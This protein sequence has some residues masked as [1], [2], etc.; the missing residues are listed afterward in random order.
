MGG[1]SKSF[2][3][4]MGSLGSVLNPIP[5]IDGITFEGEEDLLTFEN[6]LELITF[7]N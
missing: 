6:E 7:E 4:S 3:A 1:F 5:P 2:G